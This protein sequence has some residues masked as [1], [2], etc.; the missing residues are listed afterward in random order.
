MDVVAAAREAAG[1][2]IEI[3]I[4]AQGMYNVPTAIRLANQVAERDIFWL[5]EPVTVESWKA[6]KQVN[7]QIT[8]LVSAGERLHTRWDF[9]HI[10]ENGLADYIMLDVT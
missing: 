6:L 1:S 3:L 8:P 2:D 7:E 4:D 9:V 10:F 5:E